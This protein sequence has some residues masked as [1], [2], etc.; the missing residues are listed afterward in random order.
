L[1]FIA[2]RLSGLDGMKYTGFDIAQLAK[3]MLLRNPRF[4]GSETEQFFLG[5]VGAAHGVNAI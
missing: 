4:Q 5:N 2:L 3:R 1:Y